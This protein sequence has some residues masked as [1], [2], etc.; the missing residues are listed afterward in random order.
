MQYLRKCWRDAQ[1]AGV[2]LF[3]FNSSGL[4]TEYVSLARLYQS[5]LLKSFRIHHK[6]TGGFRLYNLFSVLKV[7][8]KPNTVI[9]QQT[10]PSGALCQNVVSVDSFKGCDVVLGPLRAQYKRLAQ[11]PLSLI[12]LHRK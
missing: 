4:L 3:V 5:T 1:Q 11:N 2:T 9:P 7:C 8:T 12:N 10:L 6:S